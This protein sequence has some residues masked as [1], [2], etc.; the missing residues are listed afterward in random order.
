MA[1]QTQAWHPG[2]FTKNFGWGKEQNGLSAL[3]RAIR[4]GF[5]GDR[6]DVPRGVF[7]QR[8]EAKGLNFFIPANFFLFNFTDG[9]ADLIAF[10]ELVFQA[11]SFEH[12]LDFDRLALL[13]FNLSLV[14]TWQGARL[15]QRRPA[16]WSNR[17]IIERLGKVHSWNVSKVNADDIEN[18]FAGDA[19]YQGQTTRKLSTN[20]AYLYRLAGLEQVVANRIERWWMNAAFL[21]ADRF[22]RLSL[23]P[24]PSVVS[25]RGAFD[26]FEF[27]ELTGGPT[28]EKHYALRRITQ[29]FASVGGSQRFAKSAD[30]LASGATND[31]RPFGLVDKKLPRA[32]KSLPPG[33][34]G[35]LDLLDS[36]FGY[37][38]YDEL[39]RFEPDAFVR[40]GALRALRRIRELGAV[41][42]MTSDD[43][44][45]LLRD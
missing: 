40:E 22:A 45:T 18:F 9:S 42:T 24:Q 12:S 23:V 3:H 37:L 30:A 38:D 13:A 7:R 27:L 29:M 8:L 28:I 17:Y 19:R 6:H 43:L 36:S 31:P 1:D 2:S 39:R 21:S 16:L 41:P 33:V 34:D 26:A 4:I 35:G 20:L 14:G 11:I 15:W 32:P 44:M 5:E 25:L 10:D